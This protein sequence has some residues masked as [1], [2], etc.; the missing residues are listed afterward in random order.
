M[1]SGNAHVRDNDCTVESNE[2]AGLVTVSF[3]SDDVIL[4]FATLTFPN[5]SGAD[6]SYDS[7]TSDGRSNASAKTLSSSAIA[8]FSDSDVA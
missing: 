7:S 2:A 6:E 5:R 4:G 3:D 1:C 8:A